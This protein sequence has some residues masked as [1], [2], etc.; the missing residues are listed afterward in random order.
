MGVPCSLLSPRREV[1]AHEG[2]AKRAV[3]L[4]AGSSELSRRAF[5]I[6]RFQKKS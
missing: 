5:L 3:S 6:L 1:V 2:V 4:Q